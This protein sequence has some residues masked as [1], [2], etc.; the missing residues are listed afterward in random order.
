MSEPLAFLLTWTVYG[1]WLPGDERYWVKKCAGFQPPNSARKAAAAALL[2]EP[3]FQ[4]TDEQRRIVEATIAAHCAIRGWTLHAVNCR[5]NHVHVV[6]SANLHPD[7]I[8]GQFKA[9]CTRRLKK[10]LETNHVA[11]RYRWWTEGSSTRYINHVQGL[12]A[13]VMY[14]R[15]AQ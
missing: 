11:S 6:V 8:V 13:A 10:H 5:T 12:D 9:W 2:K 14:V 1:T 7:Q 4:L 15:D 3:S